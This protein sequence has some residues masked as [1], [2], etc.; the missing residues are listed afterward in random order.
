MEPEQVDAGLFERLLG[1]ASAVEVDRPRAAAKILDQAL[2]LW[3]GPA[4]VEFADEPFAAAEAARLDEL[5]LAA[6]ERRFDVDLAVGAHAVLVGQ[7]RAFHGVHPLRERPRGQLMLALYRCGRQAEALEAFTEYRQLLDDELGLEPSERLRA[8][9]AAIL[10]QAPELDEP[11]PL[12][13][14]STRTS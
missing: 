9:Q 4:L 8:Q 7:L 12:P 13:R 11:P 10:R 5:R 14:S 1:K 2:S 3:R 6:M